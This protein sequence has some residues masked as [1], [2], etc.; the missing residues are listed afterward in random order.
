M[1][2]YTLLGQFKDGEIDKQKVIDAIDESK[3]GM[4]PRSR[5][6]DKNTEI[7]ELKEEISKRDEQI[8]KLQD[9]VKDD[10]EIQKELEELKNQNSEWE[11]KYKET[12]LNNAVKLAVAKEANDAN[13][14][15]AFINKD[16]LELADDGTVKGLD[17]AVETLKES[18]PY[19]FASSKPT[20][21]SPQ[22]GDNPTGKPTKEDFKKMTYT[23]QVELLNSDPDLYRELSN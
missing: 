4:V 22:Q 20:G 5:L 21:N 7:E 12:Q 17:K 18:K 3:S 13:D 9:S 23:E 8:V 11:T 1:D 15:L 16:E 14:I 10:S 6:N 19:L 2:L